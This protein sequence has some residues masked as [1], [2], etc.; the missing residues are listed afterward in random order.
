VCKREITRRKAEYCKMK[1]LRNAAGESSPTYL[2]VRSLLVLQFAV[3]L[4]VWEGRCLAL[5]T[6][7]DG[8]D[9]GESF[10]E[11][12][13]LRPLPDHKILSH[14]YF[15]NTLRNLGSAAHHHVFP[16]AISQLVS[17]PNPTFLTDMATF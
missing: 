10:S 8:W 14:F 6:H 1:I 15:R 3:S 11:D 7:D 17:V 16:K 2:F 9:N 4:L 12:L 13:F 5:A